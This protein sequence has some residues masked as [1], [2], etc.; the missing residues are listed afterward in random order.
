MQTGVGEGVDGP[1]NWRPNTGSL[2]FADV[3]NPLLEHSSASHRTKA[4]IFCDFLLIVQPNRQLDINKSKPPFRSLF[5]Q[6][7]ARRAL[8]CNLRL[9]TFG[10]IIA[11]AVSECSHHNVTAYSNN[12]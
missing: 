7:G 2:L 12:S 3:R 9:R 10:C 5:M 8:S 4:M 6:V 11:N 1:R